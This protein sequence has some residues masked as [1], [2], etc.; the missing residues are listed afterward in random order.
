MSRR[1]AALE[2][3]DDDHAAAAAGTW[4]GRDL[5]PPAPTTAAGVV[6]LRLW[7]GHVEQLTG[8]GDVL[9]APAIGEEAVMA[10]AMEAIGEH[11]E[12]EAAGGI[13]G[14]GGHIT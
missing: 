12:K 1:G 3:L 13:R 9:D 7:R 2:G 10:D 4:I 6:G 11:V 5:R 14:D 8:A